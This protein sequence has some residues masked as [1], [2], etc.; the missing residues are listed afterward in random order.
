MTVKNFLERIFWIETQVQLK[1]WQEK[2]GFHHEQLGKFY[3]EIVNGFDKLVEGYLGDESKS[4][5]ISDELFKLD[6]D[7]DSKTII[8]HTRNFLD[9]LE[10][11]IEFNERGL[12]NLVDDLYNINEK[13]SYLLNRK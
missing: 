12:E 1:H 11:S 9:D 2:S 5:S 4:I 3:E 10:E 6:N 7:L 13:Y 8:E